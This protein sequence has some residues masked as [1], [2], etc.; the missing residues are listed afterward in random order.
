MNFEQLEKI[1]ARNSS[2]K[3]LQIKSTA[4]TTNGNADTSIAHNTSINSIMNIQNDKGIEQQ[5]NTIPTHMSPKDIRN[6]TNKSVDKSF[7]TNDNLSF[8]L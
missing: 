8:N 4:T 2:S 1:I 5:Q 3:G 6:L 7:F